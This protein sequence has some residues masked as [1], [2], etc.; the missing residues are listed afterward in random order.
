MSDQICKGCGH[1]F[2]TGDIVVAE[3][4]TKFVALKSK[5]HYALEKPTECF[6]VEHENCYDPKGDDNNEDKPS[7]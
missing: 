4:K 2:E 6:W 1:L 3:I 7:V 5:I